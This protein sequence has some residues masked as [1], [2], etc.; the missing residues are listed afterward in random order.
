MNTVEIVDSTHPLYGETLPL[1]GLTTKQVLGRVA[2]VWI[3]P[4]IERMIPLRATSLADPP[5]PEPYPCRLSVASVERLLSVV[6]S[7]PETGPEEAHGEDR[8]TEALKEAPGATRAAP[9]GAS[10]A[11]RPQRHSSTGGVDDAGTAG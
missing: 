5:A 6:A 3:H 10:P 2:I 7:L 8:T 11:T 4:G 1:V 9:R